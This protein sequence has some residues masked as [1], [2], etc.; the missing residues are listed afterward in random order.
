MIFAL[1]MALLQDGDIE[2]GRKL[3]T[4]RCV[5]CHF[6]PDATIARDR[7]WTELIKTTA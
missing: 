5:N 2:A 6:V 3:F 1:A 7:V 4:Q